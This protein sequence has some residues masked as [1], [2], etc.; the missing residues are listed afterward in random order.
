M[1]GA[2][3]PSDMAPL[4]LLP[5]WEGPGVLVDS[6]RSALALGLDALHRSGCAPVIHLPAIICRSVVEICHRKGFA[7]RYYSMG[8]S[9]KKP[10]FLDLPDPADVV[11]FVHILGLR[12]VVME[13]ILRALPRRPF[14]VEDGA[15]SGLT[16]GVGTLGDV[17]ILGFRK[18]LPIPDG[19][20]VRSRFPLD[21]ASLA[22]P[23]GNFIAQRVRELLHS[24]PPPTWGPD[25]AETRLDNWRF[26]RRISRWSLTRLRG[27]DHAVVGAQRR[28]MFLFLAAQCRTAMHGVGTPLW[29]HPGHGIPLGFP[30]VFYKGYP[31]ELRRCLRQI[32]CPLPLDWAPP[33]DS[34]WIEDGA[35]LKRLVV[36]PTAF[37][38][39]D[40]LT[41]TLDLVRRFCRKTSEKTTYLHPSG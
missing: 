25:V 30:L 5:P 28:Q 40:V 19:A 31:G 39:G 24:T 11:L 23:D 1:N 34:P 14:V 18:L 3:S 20:L 33:P 10:T 17:V 32:G 21:V 41:R 9:M 16:P 15:Q 22:P 8:K 35:F 6:G 36:L 13:H 12:N 37:P 4:P 27:R 2:I 29:E 38:P 7:V 26:P